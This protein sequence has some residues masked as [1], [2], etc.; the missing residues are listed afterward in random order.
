MARISIKATLIVRVI[1]LD[2]ALKIASSSKA[3]RCAQK[4]DNKKTCI[5][6]S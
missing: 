3:A 1:R 5:Q 4:N 6:F 2:V